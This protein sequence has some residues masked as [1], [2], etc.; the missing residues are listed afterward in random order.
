MAR[1]RSKLARQKDKELRKELEGVKVR[2]VLDKLGNLTMGKDYTILFMHGS[3]R[4]VDDDGDYYCLNNKDIGA[5][6]KVL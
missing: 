4:V 6:F 3:C 5:L 2:C 1:F